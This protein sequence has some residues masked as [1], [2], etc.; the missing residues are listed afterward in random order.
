MSGTVWFRSGSLYI[1][2][3]ASTLRKKKGFGITIYERIVS[4]SHLG[5]KVYL[6]ILEI[7][8]QKKVGISQI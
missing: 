8:C 6:S 2:D 1:D 5:G 3:D 7:F 4:V